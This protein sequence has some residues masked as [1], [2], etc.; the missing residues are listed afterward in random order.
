[1]VLQRLFRVGAILTVA[2]LLLTAC[3][4]PINS[5]TFQ[6]DQQ[7]EANF[8]THKTEFAAL[9]KFVQNCK[10]PTEQKPDVEL[11]E[12]VFYICPVSGS[13][14]KLK[15]V[16]YGDAFGS[17]SKDRKTL[18]IIFVT[19]QTKEEHG[20]IFVEEK[21]YIFSPTPIQEGLVE[22]GSLD[23]F[24]GKQIVEKRSIREIWKYKKINGGWHL[25]FRQY[26][27]QFFP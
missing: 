27:Q 16:A 1:M 8:Q 18:P 11:G 22:Q 7:L 26:F 10:S 17:S 15:E 5:F 21:G 20:E 25:Y 14:L 13:Q 3:N 6:S 9:L 19:D 24:A 4:N 23:Q 12:T 2:T